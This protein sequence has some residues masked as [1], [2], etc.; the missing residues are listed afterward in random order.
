MPGEVFFV[1]EHRV[2]VSVRMSDLP[3]LHPGTTDGGFVV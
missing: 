2:C 1:L 3:A